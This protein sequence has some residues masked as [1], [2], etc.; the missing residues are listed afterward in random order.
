MNYKCAIFDM[1]GTV[2][3]SMHMWRTLNS[4]Y[5]A[6]HGITVDDELFHRLEHMRLEQA[7]RF[8]SDNYEQFRDLTAE[9]AFDYWFRKIENKY[10]TEIKLKAHS[11]EFLRFIRSRGVK[12]AIAS[13]TD[14][15]LIETALTAQGL[16]GQFD[17]I[18]CTGE[19]GKDKHSPD[20]YF[21]CMNALGFT[22]DECAV[23]EDSLYAAKTASAAGF[24]TVG[25]YDKY[26]SG[27]IGEF[28]AVC[29][30]VIYDWRELIDE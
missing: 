26:T 21:C 16:L 25:M 3:D 10:K 24:Y 17:Y 9:Q 8:F 6:E 29:D 4:D 18:T 15:P 12:T 19:V 28:S 20:I 30:R 11:D 5:L 23:F 7:V 2:L 14:K 13:V 1:D 22:Q 27:D